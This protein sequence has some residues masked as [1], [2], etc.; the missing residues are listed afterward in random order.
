MSTRQSAGAGAPAV[1]D[2]ERSW[3]EAARLRREH[4]AWLVIWLASA[5][6]YRA[7]RRA[8]QARH[9]QAL[10]ADTPDELAD[11]ITQAEQA[12]RTPRSTPRTGHA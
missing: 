8:S 1:T 12:K 5:R 3:Q 4:P 6:Q 2:D 11:R 10:C 7:Y 9:E